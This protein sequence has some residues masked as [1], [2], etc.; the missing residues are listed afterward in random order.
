MINAAIVGLGWWGKT[1]V[2]AVQGKSEKIRFVH[3]VS[4]EPDSVRDYAKEKGFTLST[5]LEA[6][7]AEAKAFCALYK[8]DP[9]AILAAQKFERIMLC[10]LKRRRG[11][12]RRTARPRSSRRCA[13]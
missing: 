6:A 7:L 12:P 10:Q 8:V 11:R 1:I 2:N 3:G 13:R 5:T 4:F 9:A